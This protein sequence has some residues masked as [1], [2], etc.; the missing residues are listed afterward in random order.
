MDWS[1][2]VDQITGRASKE[3]P[4]SN[5]FNLE[6]IIEHFQQIN[7]D[8]HYESPTNMTITDDT[9]VPIIDD[10]T[11]LNFLLAV[12][13]TAAGPDIIGHWFWRDLALGL[14]LAITYLFNLSIKSQVVPLQW[15]SANITPF[16]KESSVSR[17]EEIKT[18]L[19]YRHYY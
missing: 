9:Y 15:K 1:K 14:A 11:T 3:V 13:R 4:L 10:S 5:F 8:C 17:M 7:T 2:T 16:S 12:K 19:S 18:Y 6:D